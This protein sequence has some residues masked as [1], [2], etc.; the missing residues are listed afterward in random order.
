MKK[1]L[2]HS[3]RDAQKRRAA[4]AERYHFFSGH[5]YSTNGIKQMVNSGLETRYLKY[6]L[7]ES[8]K[9]REETNPIVCF[10]DGKFSFSEQGL[11]A[12]LKEKGAD[13]KQF[14]LEVQE[15]ERLLD[16]KLSDCP[17]HVFV[18]NKR[19]H[20]ITQV[21]TLTYKGIQ[22]EITRWNL[23][24]SPYG[25]YE[26][27][28]A[29]EMT[30]RR[31][32]GTI[33][34][35]PWILRDD[36]F[37]VLDLPTLLMDL[38]LEYQLREEEIA[39]HTKQ[40][41]IAKMET[42]VLD[43]E[44]ISLPPIGQ[45]STESDIT[46][47]AQPWMDTIHDYL[48]RMTNKYKDSFYMCNMSIEPKENGGL[49]ILYGRHA[50][51]TMGRP[52]QEAFIQLCKE[53][54]VEGTF[55]ISETKILAEPMRRQ[56]VASFKVGEAEIIFDEVLHHTTPQKDRLTVFPYAKDRRF[57]FQVHGSI[58]I[59]ALVSY[60]KLMPELCRQM[61]ELQKKIDGSLN[62]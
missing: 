26:I 25:V 7:G 36:E 4:F 31:G 13:L 34:H 16:M 29:K 17:D 54:Q 43:E 51:I 42:A 37:Y 11:R 61:D 24:G 56:T 39:Y 9:H 55:T 35:D 18:Y 48:V 12:S 45:S 50:K 5:Q 60:L 3:E 15:E 46:T 41:L 44:S 32:D 22:M 2:A 30:G 58:G 21:C 38:A 27:I 53:Q 6:Y 23:K 33:I 47:I 59:H 14:K 49:V 40:Q 8:Y 57:Q 28:P 19:Q 20:V 52:P 62:F 1:I 10:A